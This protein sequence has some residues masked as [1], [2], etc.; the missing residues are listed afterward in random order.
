VTLVTGVDYTARALRLRRAAQ[1][2]PGP[3][4]A[5][6]PADQAAAET[7]ATGQS[8]LEGSPEGPSAGRAAAGPASAGPAAAGPGP[9]GQASAGPAPGAGE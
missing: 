1:G 6:Q 5:G 2:P 7:P 8:P 4:Q 3:V 9:A